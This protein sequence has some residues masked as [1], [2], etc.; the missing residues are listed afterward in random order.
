MEKHRRI[1][2]S[3]PE[4]IYEEVKKYCFENND[5]I[6]RFLSRIAALRFKIKTY[7]DKKENV[8]QVALIN[9]GTFTVEGVIEALYVIGDSSIRSR[10][11]NVFP[12]VDYEKCHKLY[13]M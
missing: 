7:E 10:L 9:D 4:R 8:S 13:I 2:I 11:K 5:K 6:S 1:N 3:I 12:E